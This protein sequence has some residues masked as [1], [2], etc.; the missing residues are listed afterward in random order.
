MDGLE[1]LGGCQEEGAC[2]GGAGLDSRKRPFESLQFDEGCFRLN[3]LVPFFFGILIDK[4]KGKSTFNIK[5]L[6]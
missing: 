1:H 4:R 6:S 2:H 5:V 3:C